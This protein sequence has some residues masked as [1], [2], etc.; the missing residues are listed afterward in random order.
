MNYYQIHKEEKVIVLT[1][2]L[3]NSKEV[4]I[5]LDKIESEVNIEAIL[6]FYEELIEIAKMGV[7][8]DVD[9][10]NRYYDAYSKSFRYSQIRL[11]DA[12]RCLLS[13]VKPLWEELYKY[14]PWYSKLWFKIKKW[15]N[16]K[17]I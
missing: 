10:L 4:L 15:L 12:V 9:T 2:I 5:K 13:E 1:S 3:S 16:I 8:I 17:I 7:K 6:P 11:G 14:L